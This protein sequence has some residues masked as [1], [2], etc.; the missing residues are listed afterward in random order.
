[1]TGLLTL[2]AA[3]GGALVLYALI[4]FGLRIGGKNHAFRKLGPMKQAYGP[5]LGSV[6]HY[7]GYVL[8]PLLVG[9]WLVAAAFGLDPLGR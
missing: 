3:L 4:V 7:A 8:L 9:L 6:I 2:R 1:M 5:R